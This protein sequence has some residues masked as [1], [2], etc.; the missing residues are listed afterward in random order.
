MTR[1]IKEPLVQFLL[2]G[3]AIF[4]LNAV[5][6]K[7]GERT[8]DHEIRVTQGRVQSLIETFRRQ[9]SRPPTQDE[10]N[11]LVNDFVREEVLMREAVALGLDRD[12]VIVRRRL[13]QKMEFLAE[14]AA[15]VM[16]PTD[17]DLRT[18]LAEHSQA[19]FVPP[20]YTF[21]QIALDPA[22]HD[23]APKLAAELNAGRVDPHE[24]NAIRMLDVR[25]GD[26]SASDV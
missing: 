25:Q 15:S 22:K 23:V 20:R 26:V 6:T 9:W 8:G 5:L 14:D 16:E 7:R 12:D 17:L 11:G 3:I 2:I 1:W 24:A 21:N 19:F 4:G 18:Y 10:L 13:A